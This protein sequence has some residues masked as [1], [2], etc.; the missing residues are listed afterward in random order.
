[1]KKISVIIAGISLMLGSCA[2]QG[3]SSAMNDFNGLN[4]TADS[5]SYFIGVNVAKNMKQGGLNKEFSEAAYV[6]GMM[7]IFNEDSVMLDDKI[8]GEIA[9]RI[10]MA[11]QKKQQEE[12]FKEVREKGVA[13]LNDKSKE[14]DVTTLPSGLRYKIIK[15][16][17][18][19][20]P[21]P[22]DAVSTHYHGTLVDGTVFDSSVERDEPS[23]FMA[24]QVISGWKEALQLM[25]VGSK[26]ELYVPQ[27]LA[28]GENGTRGIPPFSTLI[29]EVELLKILSDEEK[30]EMVK[31]QEEQMRQMQLQQQMQ[32]LQMQQQ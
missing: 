20:K 12:Q 30:A 21:K 17:T 14:E 8:G 5:V 2:K 9:N 7:D 4:T 11:N 29:F 1:M 6:K 31:A 19:D 15:E 16:G 24:N 27:E 26:W 13:F 23:E 18:G 3:P 32:Q 10:A 25:P 28:Y 22:T